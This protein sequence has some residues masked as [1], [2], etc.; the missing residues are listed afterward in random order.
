MIMDKAARRRMEAFG[1]QFDRVILSYYISL[2]PSLMELLEE[3]VEEMEND[4]HDQDIDYDE[5]L[6]MMTESR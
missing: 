6:M 4:E 5:F 2:Q 3:T 1:R